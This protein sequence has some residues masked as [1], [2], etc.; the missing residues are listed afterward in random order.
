[1]CANE[2]GCDGPVRLRWPYP[3][4]YYGAA[5]K[6]GRGGFHGCE[7][8][9]DGLEKD[10]V[11]AERIWLDDWA[12]LGLHFRR[13]RLKEYGTVAGFLD[14]PDGSRLRTRTPTGSS[15]SVPRTS[16][17]GKRSLRIDCAA[18]P[19]SAA[20]TFEPTDHRVPR[21]E[22]FSPDRVQVRLARRRARKSSCLRPSTPSPFGGA[23]HRSPA[24]AAA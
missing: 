10:R 20:M 14:D 11:L 21:S 19:S 17:S 12:V 22:L 13:G 4:G 6:S 9:D 5:E 24:G 23:C 2:S 18:V 1:M 16:P 8:D 3:R 7:S 15:M